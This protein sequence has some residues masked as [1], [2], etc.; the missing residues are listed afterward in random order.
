[1]L[2]LRRYERISVQNRRFR[3]NGGS[4]PKILGRRSRPTNHSSS[5][6]TRLSHLSY[7]T[8]IWTGHSSVLSQCTRLTNR[9]T[10]R[11]TDSFLIAR[12]R[13]HSMQRG[14]KCCWI[15]VFKFLTSPWQRSILL[16][17]ITIFMQCHMSQTLTVL[18]LTLN[19]CQNIVPWFAN[20]R[21]VARIQQT[22][23]SRVLAD[24]YQ[25][26]SFDPRRN[27]GLFFFFF[28]VMP[29]TSI[30]WKLRS[31]STGMTANSRK[32]YLVQNL[33]QCNFCLFLSKLK[34]T[35]HG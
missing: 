25:I 9:R 4:W 24:Q 10:D 6:K 5:Q 30:R 3:S 22:N 17:L 13:L 29:T 11:Q 16:L 1:M 7:G 21:N 27:W 35:Q 23:N 31:M 26:I 34:F 19:K 14:K 20:V 18:A 15:L 8:K 2:R 28:V 33:S 12:P 32:T